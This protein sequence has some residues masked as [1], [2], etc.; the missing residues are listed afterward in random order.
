MIKKQNTKI[1]VYYLPNYLLFL[2]P[3]ATNVIDDC[4]QLLW[5]S[6][7]IM[8]LSSF[9]INLV[10]FHL[11]KTNVSSYTWIHYYELS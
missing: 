11:S 9:Q 1:T 3:K 4:I 5:M 10:L 2:G 6:F 7:L 8:N